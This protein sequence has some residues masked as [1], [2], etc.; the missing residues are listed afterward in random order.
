[1]HLAAGGFFD[2]GGA[3]VDIS[4]LQG[5]RLHA[6]AGI[7]NPARFFASLRE[8]GLDALGHAFP[9]HHAY[10]P[11]DLAFEQCDYV[12]MTAKDAVKCRAFNRTDLL[13]FRIHADPEPPFGDYLLKAVHGFSSA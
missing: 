1:M 9:D 8:L 4:A 10:Q 7:G 5:K 3:P 11:H 2:M 13:V 6:V 12:L